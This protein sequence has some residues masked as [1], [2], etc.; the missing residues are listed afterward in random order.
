MAKERV[1]IK[2]VQKVDKDG[3]YYF[4]DIYE[5]EAVAKEEPAPAVS[6]PVKKKKGA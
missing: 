5:G 2:Q 3:R 4:E 6:A 1:W